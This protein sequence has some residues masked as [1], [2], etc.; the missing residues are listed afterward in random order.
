MTKLQVALVFALGCVNTALGASDEIQIPRTKVGLMDSLR[1]GNEQ[2][3]L[4]SLIAKTGN[5]IN[6]IHEVRH[7]GGSTITPEEANKFSD[8]FFCLPKTAKPS[9]RQAQEFLLRVSTAGAKEV[10]PQQTSVTKKKAPAQ[11]T[12]SVQVY[13][14]ANSKTVAVEVLPPSTRQKVEVFHGERKEEITHQA[15]E[16]VT[17]PAPKSLVELY[18][19]NGFKDAFDPS[20]PAEASKNG[21]TDPVLYIL[22]GPAKP[23]VN[24]LPPEEPSVEPQGDTQV[25]ATV[26]DVP[27]EVAVRSLIDQTNAELNV[28]KTQL[29]KNNLRLREIEKEIAGGNTVRVEPLPRE[30]AALAPAAIHKV[31][32]GKSTTLVVS[33]GWRRP[34]YQWFSNSYL[35]LLA[36]LLLTFA[37]A[38]VCQET[39]TQRHE[40]LLH[41]AKA[42]LLQV[43]GQDSRFIIELWAVYDIS[44]RIR[45]AYLSRRSKQTVAD[46]LSSLAQA[47]DMEGAHVSEPLTK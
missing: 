41:R 43:N 36:V 11:S 14:G 15:L 38:G 39:L 17:Y 10:L 7:C 47:I 42:G 26:S 20:N 1:K 22:P 35:W 29:A 32:A 34:F 46:S 3:L 40:V 4:V 44:G 37:L 16:P 45:R 23:P 30:N 25:E 9:G 6:L 28:R 18:G 33:Q 27:V 5:P 12:L 8:K 24:K 13:R 21:R 2:G 31:G 19:A